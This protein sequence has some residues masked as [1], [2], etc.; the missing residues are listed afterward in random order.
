GGGT[1]RADR[2]AG[3]AGAT[4]ATAVRVVDRVHGHAAH[5]RAHA[6]PTHG[7]GLADLAQAVFFVAHFADGRAALDVHAAHFARAQAHLGVGTFTGQQH[8][9]GAGRTRQLRALAGGHLDAVDRRT[10]GDV[11]DRQRVAHAD[12]R[13]TAGN[14]RG[15]DFQAARGD[16]VATLA[17]GIAQQRDVRGAVRI[18]FQ[19]LDLGRDAVLVATEIDHAIVP[20]VPAATMAHRDVAVVVAARATGFLLEQRLD[21]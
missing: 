16:D 11:A 9:R 10:H 6:A 13:I 4:L 15:A 1:P 5:G 20:L 21:R 14:Q 8:R 18:V 3:F 2:L 7:A 17:V 12:R 19:A